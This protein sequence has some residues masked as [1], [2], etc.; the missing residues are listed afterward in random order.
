M[1][2][3]YRSRENVGGIRFMVNNEELNKMKRLSGEMQVFEYDVMEI[4]I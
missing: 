3:L 4:E 2:Y 1:K